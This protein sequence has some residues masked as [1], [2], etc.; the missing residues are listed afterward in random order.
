MEK[1][2]LANATISLYPKSNPVNK[3]TIPC[4]YGTFEFTYGKR[5]IK[6]DTC[7]SG[8]IVS[9]GAKG[10]GDYTVEIGWDTANAEAAQVMLLSA[11]DGTG[12]FATI[13]E[14]V[15][16][17]EFDNSKGISGAK[18]VV[19]G[20]VSELPVSVPTEENGKLKITYTQTADP[21]V[22]AAA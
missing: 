12:D 4:L 10:Y 13:E 21:V 5:E 15:F 3:A 6:R 14:I 7:H 17:I 1:A 19:E 20:I 16:D 2:S 22:T 8:E 11:L 18:L 9:R